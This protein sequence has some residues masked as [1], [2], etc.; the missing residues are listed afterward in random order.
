LGLL[1][2]AW[3][4]MPVKPVKPLAEKD[5]P[6]KRTPRLEEGRETRRT[7]LSCGESQS[8]QKCK[9]E[10]IMQLEWADCLDDYWEETPHMLYSGRGIKRD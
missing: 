6:Q 5:R 8:M 7:V 9:M 2:V 3:G 10:T 1:G 4:R